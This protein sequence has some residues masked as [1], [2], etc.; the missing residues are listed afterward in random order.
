[1]LRNPGYCRPSGFNGKKLFEVREAIRVMVVG[2]DTGGTFTDFV[3]FDERGKRV[4]KVLS[5]PQN[6]AGAVIKGLNMIGESG[7]RDIVHGSTVATNAILERKGAKTALVT[8]KG[9]EDIIEIG[10]QNR[11]RIYD[12][13]YRKPEPVVSPELRY[14]VNCRVFFDGTTGKA[15]D[16]TELE[17]IAEKIKQEDVESVAV[18]LLFSFL[19]PDHELMVEKILEKTGIDISLS[20]RILPEFREYERVSTTVLNAYVAPVMKRYITFFKDSIRAED[21]LRIMQSSGGSISAETATREPIRTILSGPAGG[22][23]GA[24]KVAAVSGFENIITFDMGG[25]STDVS[26]VKGDVM[27]TVKSTVGGFPVKVPMVDIHTV[28][29][30]GGS[31]AFLDRG[32]SLKVGP[33]SAGAYPGP[34]CY[35]RGGK[36]ITVTDANLFLGRLVPG[37][38][39]GGKMKL[40]EKKVRPFFEKMARES[41]MTPVELAKGVLSVANATMERAI[42]VISVE[43]GENPEEFVLV[44]FG[45]AGGLHAP[46]L[47]GNLSISTVLIPENPGVLSALG[48]LMADVTKDYSRT[49]M[50]KSDK[51]SSEEISLI[52]DELKQRG[53]SELC[54]EGIKPQDVVFEPFIDMRY[55]GQSH[56]IMVP[57]RENFADIF[58][59]YHERLFGYRKADRETEIVNV[60]LRCRGKPERPGFKKEQSKTEK[61]VPEAYIGEREVYFDDDNPQKTIVLDREKLDFGNFLQGPAIIVEY[62]ST[63]IVPPGWSCKVDCYKNLILSRCGNTC[64]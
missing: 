21:R 46:F 23:I 3:F 29:A 59:D 5:T 45:G 30:G 14:G 47:A 42:R 43:K 54:D 58:H 64:R 48:M 26:L 50:I 32:G 7:P 38:F 18:C 40:S 36:D 13:K 44:A 62:T 28:G 2:I 9:F 10:R 63:T 49:V 11:D 57:F 27:L 33:R 60:R 31:M 8:N 61:I 19:N 37:H 1:M 55:A 53:A 39:L 35:E 41:G 51:T 34:I 16:T 24:H 20:H 6:P 52:F 22:V 15:P 25:T 12:L 56:E 17:K 4:I